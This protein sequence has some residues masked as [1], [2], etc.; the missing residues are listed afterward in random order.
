MKALILEYNKAHLAH[1]VVDERGV[2]KFLDIMVR[3]SLPEGIT[4]EELVG[5]EIEYAEETPY[6]S[7]AHDVSIID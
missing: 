3:G 6:V 5:K 1:R 2:K 4:N 7:I